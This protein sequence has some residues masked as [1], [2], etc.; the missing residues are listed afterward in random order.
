MSYLA[1][2]R[3]SLVRNAAVVPV[4]D[5]AVGVVRYDGSS[6]DYRLSVAR[7]VL[8]RS[9]SGGADSK[10]TAGNVGLPRENRGRR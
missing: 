8:F 3:K 9:V 6:C 4:V 7:E 2:P 5:R 1:D 10:T